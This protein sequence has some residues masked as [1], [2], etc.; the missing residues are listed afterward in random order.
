VAAAPR[1]PAAARRFLRVRLVVGLSAAALVGLPA[2]SAAP[3][4]HAGAALVLA[5]W[6]LVSSAALGLQA[7]LRLGAV[8]LQLL[9]L[10]GDS[11][12]AALVVRATGALQSPRLLLLALPILAAGLRLHWRAGFIFGLGTA[13]LYGLLAFERTQRAMG[14]EEIWSLVVF[15][16]LLFAGMGAATGLLARR[17]AASLQE[18]ARTRSE[19]EAVRLSTDCIVASLTCGLIAVDASG[20]LRLLNPAGRVLLGLGDPGRELPAWVAERNQR[21]AEMLRAGLQGGAG[22]ADAEV[23]LARADGSRFPA[24]VKVAPI[25]SATGQRG[26]LVALFWDQTEQ[27]R[28]AA[29]AQ[30]RERMAAVGELAAGLAHEIR[31]SLKPITGSIELLERRG[32]LPA[33]ALPLFELIT[34]EADSLEAFIGQFLELSRDKALQWEAVDPEE[35][36]RRE[37]EALEAARPRAGERVRVARGSGVRIRG[38]RDWLRLVFRNLLL[39][40]L[41]AA[42]DAAVQVR[43]EDFARGGRPWVRVRVRDGGAGLQGLTEGEAFLPFRTTKP[44]GTGLG[45]PTALRGVEQHGGRIAFEPPAQG[46]PSVVVELPVDGPGTSAAAGA[47]A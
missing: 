1:L 4:E 35:L 37:A 5:G 27:K 14:P 39:N 17:M 15:H 25:V 24:W 7:R 46:G 31:N 34:R 45:L 44:Q 12:T 38:D 2:L 3:R 11:L 29:L 40:A 32:G 6:V 41:E 26:G 28:L 42:P 30:R 9:A 13:L 16:T 43:F 19:L 21:L 8:P 18:A 36:I 10:V 47:A 33:E 23:E 20:V 22:V